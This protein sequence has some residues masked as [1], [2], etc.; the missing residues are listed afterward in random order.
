MEYDQGFI[1]FTRRDNGVEVWRRSADSFNR[2]TYLTCN[3]SL[4]QVNASPYPVP[5]F[6]ENFPPIFDMDSINPA[7]RGQLQLPSLPRRGVY[8]PFA[9]LNPPT[10][11]KASRF[12]YPHL[13]MAS[14]AAHKAYIWDIPTS[15]LIQ[16]IVIDPLPQPGDYGLPQI[17]YYVEL[18]EDFVFV[19]WSFC[20]MVYY[21]AP[22]D[23]RAESTTSN[24]VFSLGLE[25]ATARD[26]ARTV[27]GDVPDSIFKVDLP[28]PLELEFETSTPQIS[29]SRPYPVTQLTTPA[30]SMSQL[31]VSRRQHMHWTFINI[32]PSGTI[33]L[34]F[35][36]LQMAATLLR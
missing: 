33:L 15:T 14:E 29:Y 3:P 31:L 21:R 19:C 20:L 25:S 36:F 7:N 34:P 10:R 13:V 1:V 24:L 16:T 9:L 8:L 23:H 6:P 28:S 22:Q 18:N 35:T 26:P 11:T 27:L 4:G 12:V 17:I 32:F 2:R 5:R 30:P